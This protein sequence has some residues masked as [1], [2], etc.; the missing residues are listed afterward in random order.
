MENDIIRHGDIIEVKFM[1][2]SVTGEVIS[3]SDITGH[4]L[5]AN[6]KKR[7]Q[8]YMSLPQIEETSI[9]NPNTGIR[10]VI[11]VDEKSKP[12]HVTSVVVDDMKIAATMLKHIRI[13]EGKNL[14][15]EA[16]PE[17]VKQNIV[18]FNKTEF[19]GAI[20]GL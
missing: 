1:S 14:K 9:K 11:K 7:F 18:R 5:I 13:P 3:I 12:Y 16:K 20:K 10:V 4:N 17:K 2:E 6:S 19:L 8:W 15:H